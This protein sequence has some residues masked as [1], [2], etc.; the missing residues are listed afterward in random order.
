MNKMDL[1]TCV[2][3][4]TR[5]IQLHYFHSYFYFPS[6]SVPSAGHPPDHLPPAPSLPL[7]LRPHLQ[8]RSVEHEHVTRTTAKNT[9]K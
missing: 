9:R 2:Y 1:Y 4:G 5:S 8:T 3:T 7:S 6:P